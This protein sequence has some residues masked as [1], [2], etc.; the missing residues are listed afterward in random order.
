[1]PNSR[2]KGMEKVSGSCIGG[3][4]VG[5]GGPRGVAIRILPPAPRSRNSGAPCR[6]GA[7]GARLVQQVTNDPVDLSFLVRDGLSRPPLA[8]EFLHP[9]LAEIVCTVCP[10]IHAP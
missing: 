10:A 8:P 3:C 4:L 9:L 7:S 6:P 2:P 1:M 5:R